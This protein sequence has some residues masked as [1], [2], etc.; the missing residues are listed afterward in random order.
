MRLPSFHL[1]FCLFTMAVMTACSNGISLEKHKTEGSLSLTQQQTFNWASNSRFT[2][3]DAVAGHNRDFDVLVRQAVNQVL[4]DKGYTFTQSAQAD[5]SVDYRINI[6]EE[7]VA[8]D[9]AYSQSENDQNM[10]Y[11]GP[12]W[13]LGSSDGVYQGFED[14]EEEL[15]FLQ[16]GRLHIGA[17]S[18]EKTLVWHT[19]AVK[20]LNSQKTDAERKQVIQQAVQKIMA[21]FPKQQ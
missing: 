20:L 13:K 19:S 1:L 18:P 12:T 14:P 11:Y 10:N 3:T 4:T 2:D 16:K 17:F 7:V 21:T 9:A 5:F 15:I 8:T 6:K